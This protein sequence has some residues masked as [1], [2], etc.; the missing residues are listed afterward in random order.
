MKPVVVVQ[1][2]KLE[3]LPPVMALLLSLKEQGRKVFFIG[4]PSEAGE[5]FL[6]KNG[7][8]YRFLPYKYEL[9]L[10]NTLVSKVTHR[11]ERAIRFYPC[12]CALNRFIREIAAEN[13]EPT[14]WFADTQSAALMGNE[15]FK[16]KSAVTIFELAE[17]GGYNWWG[18]DFKR[19]LQEATVVVPEYNRAHLIKEHYRLKKLPCVIANKPSGHPRKTDVDLPEEAKRVFEEIGDRPVFLYQGVWTEDR[20]DV[21]LIL[22][23]IAKE[24]PNYCVLTLPANDAVKKLLAPYSK[25]FALPYI[26]PPNH[27]AVTSRATVGIAVYNASGKTDLQRLNAIYCAPN[28][29][30]EYAGFGIPTLGN[31]IP[32][33]KY[34]IESAGAGLCAEMTR[35]SILDA[36]DRLVADIEKFRA[37]ATKFFDETDLNAQVADVLRATEEGE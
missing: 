28:K 17:K 20:A 22:E 34:T 19:Y 24:R 18:F 26:A 11:I 25:A 30:Y 5:S 35:E 36:A 9:Y 23:T 29:I 15:V 14:L 12:R 4:V 16:Y 3:F 21:G 2:K 7:I 33:L 1:Y 10:N 31:N 37:N 27:L 8:A 32:G 6:E 13:G